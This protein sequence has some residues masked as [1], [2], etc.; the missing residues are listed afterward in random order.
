VRAAALPA[1]KVRSKDHGKFIVGRKYHLKMTE[2]DLA[3]WE[4][5][6]AI[7]GGDAA[8]VSQ[9]LAASPLLASARFHSGAT[10]QTAEKYYLGQIGRYVVA[11]DTALHIAAAAYET[12]LARKL[13]TAGSDVHARNRLGDEP[14]HAAAVGSPGSR[15]WNPSAQA[16]TII[17][18]IKAGADPNTVDKR[19][20][21]A[22]HRAV[23][24]RCA[25]A[26]R[27]LLES[28]A[29]PA[30]KNGSGSTPMLL[31]IRN[32][33][34]GG[35]GSPVAKSQQQ[36][37]LRLLEQRGPLSNSKQSKA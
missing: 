15:T 14:L 5:V 16:A 22:L 21:S 30:R 24:T 27:A 36:E 19:G 34:R 7:V 9:L 26:V 35:S 6:R 1:P 25:A 8:G 3:L 12:E 13:I 17:C 31:A 32:T 2:S 11:G 20:V 23:R 28:G 10:R 18:L 29:D 33:G 4:L 37:I